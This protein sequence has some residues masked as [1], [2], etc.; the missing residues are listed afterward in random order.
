MVEQLLLLAEQDAR[1]AGA[2]AGSRRG[3]ATPGALPFCAPWLFDALMPSAC[4]LVCMPALAP[5]SAHLPARP[6]QRLPACRF[7]QLR[8]SIAAFVFD[9]A[10][11]HMKPDSLQRVLAEAEPPGLGRTLRSAY[12]SAASRLLGAERRRRAFWDNMLRLGGP[13][14][15]RPQLY[16]YR[17][18]G[19]VAFVGGRVRV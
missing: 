1:W 14:W 17:R 3:I 7:P 12:F 11:A 16:L 4:G 2:K 9:S 13:G 10:P 19:A 6:S 18:A 5:P 15:H 8:G